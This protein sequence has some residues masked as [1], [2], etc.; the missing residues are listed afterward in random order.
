MSKCARYDVSAKIMVHLE[1][2]VITKE[3]AISLLRMEAGSDIVE[4][5]LGQI[6]EALY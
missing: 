3:R 5:A 6:L 2:F 1:C 4:V